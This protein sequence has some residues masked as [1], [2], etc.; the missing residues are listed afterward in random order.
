M[1]EDDVLLLKCFFS[2]FW[3]VLKYKMF[4]KFL[5]SCRDWVF[6]KFY[7]FEKWQGFGWFE[8]FE[9]VLIGIVGGIL[10]VWV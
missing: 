5:K 7:Y 1:I 4:G 10:V 2:Y 9:F 8:L 6:F 3:Y